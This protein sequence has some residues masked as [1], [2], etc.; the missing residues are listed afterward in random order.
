MKRYPNCSCA[1]AEGSPCGRRVTDG[2]QPPVC[3]IHRAQLNNGSVGVPFQPKPVVKLTP[4]EVVTKLM[5]DPDSSVRLRACDLLMKFDA[6]CT[7]CVAR[8]RKQADIDALV[9][10]ASD[11]DRDALR[12]LMRQV[13]AVKLRIRNGPARV[14]EPDP[15]VAPPSPVVPAPT[16]LAEDEPDVVLTPEEVAMGC[17]VEDGLVIGPEAH[18]DSE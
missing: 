14:D 18:D 15:V 12:D 10:R 4:L 1:C 5:D 11:E 13:A 6:T 3:H 16:P 8:A 9:D 17:H 2:S 7:V